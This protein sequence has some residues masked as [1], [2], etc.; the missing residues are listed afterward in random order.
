MLSMVRSRNTKMFRDR[1]ESTL[2]RSET[3]P[4]TVLVWSLLAIVKHG[5][6]LT[7]GAIRQRTHVDVQRCVHMH[8]CTATY[9]TVIST[10]DPINIPMCNV[11]YLSTVFAMTMS[12]CLSI[13]CIIC[14]HPLHDWVYLQT[15]PQEFIAAAQTGDIQEWPVGANAGGYWISH[16]CVY[17]QAP[18]ANPG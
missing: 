10:R 18:G 5:F 15:K 13:Y 12:V 17:M 16:I 1:T 8:Q 4:G 14:T 7:Y 6:Q 9:G 2:F 11:L 3:R